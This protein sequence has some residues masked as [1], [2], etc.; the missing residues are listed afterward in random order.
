MVI[1]VVDTVSEIPGSKSWNPVNRPDPYVRMWIG[2]KGQSNSFG[3]RAMAGHDMEDEWLAV[4]QYKRNLKTDDAKATYNFGCPFFFD[5]EDGLLGSNTTM[6]GDTLHVELMEWNQLWRNRKIGR[7]FWDKA[8]GIR[9][10]KFIRSGVD[11]EKDGNFKAVFEVYK[12]DK[13]EPLMLKSEPVTI[14]MRF[15]VKS[16]KGYKVQVDMRES[17]LNGIDGTS[18]M[19]N[20]TQA[21]AAQ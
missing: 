13:D 11:K 21:A 8:E 15:Y 6:F 2:E 5:D 10:A 16:L 17:L 1:A 14:S 19:L 4:T 12:P 7:V 18:S 20:V 9:L 3:I